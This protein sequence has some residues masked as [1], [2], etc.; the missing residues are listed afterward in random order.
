ML[1]QF[2][3]KHLSDDALFDDLND[4]E[5]HDCM[6]LVLLQEKSLQ[7]DGQGSIRA[8]VLPLIYRQVSRDLPFEQFEEVPPRISKLL[9]L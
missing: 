3:A 2:R 7:K 9:L 1:G 5:L 4:D 6:R 8:Y